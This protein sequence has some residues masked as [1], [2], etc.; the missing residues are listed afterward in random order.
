MRWRKLGP[1][2]LPQR[3]PGWMATHAAL[4]FVE[5]LDRNL[6]KV[7]FSGRDAANRSHTGSCLVDLREPNR[8]REWSPAPLLS[9]GE[10]GGFDD[11]G[12]MLSWIARRDARRFLYYI[13]WNLGVTVPFR[14]A[15]GL[16]ILEADGG[17]RRPVPGPI[18]DRSALEPHFVAS[19]CVLP[20]PDGWRMWYL[21]CS[22]WEPAE[23]K[24]RH[25]YHIRYA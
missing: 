19:C 3:R 23:G 12:A 8:A 24:P 6:L 7:W 5:P 18:L 16:A 2:E 9:P 14:N 1:V 15:I 13:G 10:L 21:A 11:S 4:P 22:G 20:E 25:R 17:L